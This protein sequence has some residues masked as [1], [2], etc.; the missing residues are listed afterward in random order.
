METKVIKIDFA[1]FA[2][3]IFFDG[4]CSR[5]KAQEGIGAYGMVVIA[6]DGNIVYE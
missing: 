4:A 6:P 1:S 2:A 3:T 5:P